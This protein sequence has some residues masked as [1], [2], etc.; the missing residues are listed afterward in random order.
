VSALAATVQRIPRGLPRELVGALA[1]IVVGLVL[2]GGASPF[3]AQQWT[4]WLIYGLLALSF[5]FIWGHGGI[6]SFGQ[7]AFFGIGG[8]TYG[9]VAINRIDAS[10]ETITAV[11]A[12]IVVAA[13]AA[14]LLGYFIFYGNVGEVYVAIITLATSLVLLTFMSSTAGPQYHIGDAQLGGYN[15]MVGIPPLSYGKSDGVPQALT[16]QQLLELFVVLAVLVV[17]GLRILLRRPFGRVLI[18]LRTNEPRTQLLGYDVRRHKLLAFML[19]GAIAGLAGAGYAAWGLFINPAVFALSQAAMVAIYVLVGGRSSLLGA[20]VGVVLIEEV[21]SSLGGSGSTATPIVLGGLLI[22]VVLLLPQ[23]VVPGLRALLARV[24]PGLA[25]GRAPLP[26]GR[27]E[28]SVLS[29]LGEDAEPGSDGERASRLRVEGL[30]KRFGGLQALDGVALELPGRGISSVIGANGA[31]KSTF[32]NLLVGRF[33]PSAGR[34]L[35]GG[36]DITRRRPDQRA[37][38]GVGI[39]LQVA[40]IYGELSAFENV[41]LAAYARRRSVR[42]ANERALAVL[43]WLGLEQRAQEPA[44]FLSHGQQQWLEIGMVVAA[45]PR[46]ILLDEPTAGMTRQETARTAELVK[47]LAQRAAVIVVEHDMEFVRL[48]DAPV[49]M[50]HEG[51][52]FA[53][54]S[55]AELRDDER[56]L[57]VY[58]GRSAHA[59]R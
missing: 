24:L 42:G 51:R 26:A 35:L 39:K 4:S 56:V 12:A 17:L 45:E 31:G 40:S 29:P 54:G 11:L 44:G 21:S 41:W 3:H 58:L 34:V 14:G 53:R 33:P 47:T 22:V 49:T 18:A 20:F 8:Y 59:Q 37:R 5:T 10:G 1:V 30:G 6:F 46:V 25:A 7:A 27:P 48:L 19:G 52:L 55:L 38:R 15:G 36:E 23:G 9:V 16:N 13:L 32:F 2:A 43:A 28:A 57:D 50:F